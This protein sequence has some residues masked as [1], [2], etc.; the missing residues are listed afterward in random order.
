MSFV[1]LKFL[2]SPSCYFITWQRILMRGYCSGDAV[3]ALSPAFFHN[4]PSLSEFIS[5]VGHTDR[6]EGLDVGEK[7]VERELTSL[8]LVPLPFPPCYQLLLALSNSECQHDSGLSLELR[9]GGFLP[10]DHL[11]RASSSLWA[12]I[13]QAGWVFRCLVSGAHM[14]AYWLPWHQSS[15]EETHY[16]ISSLIL[17]S[18]CTSLSPPPPGN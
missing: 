8:A 11:S 18:F 13:S 5:N 14:A 4:L 17:Q 2:L 7:P 12:G 10:K 3:G 6:A 9:L 15:L 1:V 16:L